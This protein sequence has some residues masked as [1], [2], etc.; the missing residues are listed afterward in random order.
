MKIVTIEDEQSIIDAI[1]VA[2][3]FRW[4]EAVLL[5]ANTGT[6]GIALVRKERPDLV[7][8]DINLPDMTGFHVLEAIRAFS[9]V[10]VIILTVRA[11][12]ADVLRGLEAG[13]DDYITK[14][15]NYLTL[16]ARV[17][18][19]L[20]R[21][22]APPIDKTSD[23]PISARVKIDFVDQRVTVDGAPVRLT[24]VEYRFFVLL[25]KNKDKVVDYAKIAEEVWETDYEGQTQNI[26]IYA[27]RLRN[28][29]GDNPPK[30]I[31]NH[32]GI[33]YVFKG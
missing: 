26:R 4:P 16:L 2:L 8:L 18:A 12:D 28:K 11:E 29:L 9:S 23:T 13:A 31:L 7:M 27:R 3:E 6:D 24:P 14:P 10:P 17:K 25:A 20:R 19:V 33:G 22:E 21:A 30:M 32:H 15:F 1:G 5:A